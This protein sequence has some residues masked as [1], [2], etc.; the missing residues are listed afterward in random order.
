V[1]RQCK[2]QDNKLKHLVGELRIHKQFRQQGLCGN[3]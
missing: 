2:Q 3:R 1:E